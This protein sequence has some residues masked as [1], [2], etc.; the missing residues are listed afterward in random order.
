MT[1][2]GGSGLIPLSGGSATPSQAA[3]VAPSPRAK[4]AKPEEIYRTWLEI[5]EQRIAA[6]QILIGGH[7]ILADEPANAAKTGVSAVLGFFDTLAGQVF[8][9]TTD[10]G[11]LSNYM[12]GDARRWRD[13][14]R[15][16]R[17][18]SV[19]AK[20]A[21]RYHQLTRALAAAEFIASEPI[22]NN[23]R[24]EFALTDIGADLDDARR[25]AEI[26]A[27]FMTRLAAPKAT[28]NIAVCLRDANGDVCGEAVFAAPVAEAHGQLNLLFTATLAAAR[29]I[30][31]VE[32][33]LT[34]RA[35]S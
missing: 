8:T 30:A 16:F 1:S 10:V 26:S 34:R 29:E 31:N 4:G 12:A 21:P 23:E 18:R 3:I 5:A 13:L 27:N 7:T 2:F 22:G 24:E 35:L 19:A 32:V 17:Q 33:S 9:R 11:E 28:P 14:L 25:S 20:E 6:E 15:A